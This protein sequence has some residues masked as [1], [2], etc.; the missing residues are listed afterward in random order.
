MEHIKDNFGITKVGDL[1]LGDEVQGAGQVK[2]L[3]LD[4]RTKEVYIEFFDCAPAIFANVN[5]EVWVN[6]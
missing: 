3:R 6:I 4:K 2:S 5:I 1:H